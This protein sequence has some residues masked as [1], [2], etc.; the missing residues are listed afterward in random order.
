VT[1]EELTNEDSA[2]SDWRTLVWDGESSTGQ[3]RAALRKAI[4]T[5]DVLQAEYDD[6]ADQ[7]RRLSDNANEAINTLN[8]RIVELN[9][10]VAA[11]NRRANHLRDVVR[12]LVEAL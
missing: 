1:D 9:A 2:W 7:R 3:L 4:G 6:L 8:R 11:S 5:L 12:R 10:E